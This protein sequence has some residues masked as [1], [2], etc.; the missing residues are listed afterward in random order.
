MTWI[1]AFA[2]KTG[3]VASTPTRGQTDAGRVTW[4]PAF[5][6]KTGVGHPGGDVD[7]GFRRKDGRG[8]G[9]YANLRANGR[10]GGDVDSGF[11]RKTELAASGRGRGFRLSPERRGWAVGEGTWIPAFTGKTGV[12][13]ST[14]TRGQ[15][16][17][18]EGTWIPAF[19]GKTGVAASGRGRGFGLSPERR[20]GW[21]PS[22]SLRRAVLWSYIGAES[23][24]P[25]DSYTWATR[26]T[27]SSSKALPAI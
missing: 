10:R 16:D 15:T 12:A 20:K 21:R 17:A 6:G 1:P 2:G 3:G 8:G 25:S 23:C 11:R 7:S 9:I 13:A 27:V 18:G 4:V 5:A 26:S 19:A 14:P 24:G 22:D